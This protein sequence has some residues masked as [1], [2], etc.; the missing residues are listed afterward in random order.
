MERPGWNAYFI[1]YTNGTYNITG[2]YVAHQNV[3]VYNVSVVKAVP[4]LTISMGG[5]EMGSPN[6][7]STIYVPLLP[8]QFSYALSPSI[9]A[10]MLPGN[11]A[12]FNYSV[13]M[14]GGVVAAGSLS[15][16]N[17]TRTL[18][19]F[20]IP[21]GSRLSVTFDT[22]GNANYS[23]VDPT[24][25][26]IPVNIVEYVNITLTNS[27]AAATQAPF[28]QMLSVNSLQYA[29]YETGNLMNV[30]FFYANGIIVPSWLEG[31]DLATESAGASSTSTNTL[32]W[33]SIANGIAAS[34][35]INVYM[36][37][38]AKTVSLLSNAINGEA[39]QLSSKWGYYDDGGTVFPIYSNGSATFALTHTGSGGSGPSSTATAPSPY[40]TA[41]TGSVAGGGSAATTWTTD[42]E[43]SVA[44]PSNYVA[45][46]MVQLSG[47]APLTDM[48]TNVQSI[49]GGRFY[50][51][52]FDARSGQ[53]DLIGYYASGGTST[54]VISSAA[55]GS[56]TATWYQMTVVDAG[57]QL[58]LYKNTVFDYANFGTQEVAP[59]A[60]QGYS[61]GGLAVTT[62]GGTS[63]ED[64]T[65]MAVRAYPPNGAM[66]AASFNT[67]QTP[68][69]SNFVEAGL[70]TG[71]TWNVVY[72]GIIAYNSISVSNTVSFST[73]AGNFPYAIA[74]QVI[75]VNLWV[76]SPVYGNVLAGNT[77]SVT[78]TKQN[79]PPT[80][81]ISSN[82]LAYGNTAQ[83]TANA[84]PSTDSVELLVSG[85]QFGS[86][87]VVAGPV[88]S[89]LSYVFPVVAA[90]SYTI[91]ALDTTTLA[92]VVQ[93]LTVNRATPAITLPNF[94]QSPICGGGT[95]TVTANIVTLNNQ[96]AANVYANGA[97]I[98]QFT[99]QNTFTESASA[100]YSVVA[101][102]LGNG[103]Y[104][105]TSVSNSFAIDSSPNLPPAVLYYSCIDVSNNQVT[106][107]QGNLDVP[108]SFNAL[109]N[110]T[111]LSTNLQNA[112]FFYQNGT[113]AYSWLEGNALNAAQ[114][115]SMN[116]IANVIYWI[117]LPGNFIP[118]YSSNILYMGL[119]SQSI[120]L[121][122]G[123]TIGESPQLSGAWG[124]YD[125]GANV[126]SAY[127]NGASASGWTT[128]GSAGST[129]SAASGSPIGTNAFYANSVNGD[130]MYTNANYNS[131]G[132]YILQ[133]YAYSTGLGNLYFSA[134]STGAG[135]MYR[136]ETR[137]GNYA[138]FAKT[139]S[140]T[141]W[142][143]PS[144]SVTLSPSTWYLMSI[145]IAS[146]Q[147]AS[148]YNAGLNYYG[149]LGTDID[150]LSATYT[151][152]GGTET[153][154]ENGGYIG[155]IGDGL[156]A[157]YITY[158]N[159]MLARQ[160]PPNGIEP[161]M[162]FSAFV[163][164]PQT[165]TISL[166]TNLIAF[167]S[168][169]PGNTAETNMLVTDTNVGN[170]NAN[171]LV[172]GS[173]WVHAAHSFPVGNT[174]WDVTSD[175]SY[176]GNSLQPYPLSMAATNTVAYPAYIPSI[177]NA[178]Y[179]GLGVPLSAVAG[180][181]TQNIVVENSC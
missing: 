132:N 69:T 58:S 26:A 14:G 116:T 133:Y 100:T 27:Q 86:S 119:V 120:N 107:P 72:G 67:V 54:T 124:A 83:I 134:G 168:L 106:S 20:T 113:V 88:A 77:V 122:N 3:T 179:F 175:L 110:Q 140:W 8:G 167:G 53:T 91:N 29:P 176:M 93:I 40:T 90:G 42:G 21:A 151:D 50:V 117:R 48:M 139:I 105:P 17:V 82:P 165:C 9:S 10:S 141:S 180:A 164:A 63:T 62:D 130:Y 2:A 1:G 131:G 145:V 11:K 155:L 153:Y 128:A 61:G 41:I 81:T 158:W 138:G 137:G 157:T 70:P 57:D 161:S 16:G 34:S 28:Q 33:L 123:N 6:S 95:A 114:A 55:V 147:I 39:P 97:N 156:G 5:T 68:I 4:R 166:G 79:A 101:N 78:F 35:S 85:G 92:S 125:N 12:L 76:P 19:N 173:N 24:A 44:V 154:A 136:L 75:G 60:G 38:A 30:E 49:T 150:P 80:L 142:D 13:S 152:T 159:G 108:V 25:I 162:S 126:F 148:Y 23:A 71:S 37:F 99:T 169:Y 112:E 98:A 181:Y 52:R 149:N 46:I 118:A 87:N 172:G 171:I 32:Y 22:A 59:H 43:N 89:S 94:P 84:V 109:G 96:L 143:A 7:T 129:A 104:I 127:Y 102:T 160:Y 74:N 45:Q 73:N 47:S 31:N 111:R 163:A 36:G 51:F 174:L 66:P 121:F 135:Q 177:Y 103:N 170:T 115:T 64:W 56:S 178:L 18:G 144:G 146:G 65:M 15:S